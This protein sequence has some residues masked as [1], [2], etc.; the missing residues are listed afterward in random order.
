MPEEDA[1][2]EQ[3][4]RERTPPPLLL[5]SYDRQRV[6]RT[7]IAVTVLLHVLLVLLAL[8]QQKDKPK[9]EPPPD[10][11]AITY[12]MPRKAA[13]KP[14]P[15]PVPVP[16]PTPSKVKPR[17]APPRPERVEME[18]L[19]D[20]ITVPEEKVVEAK[21]APPAAPAPPPPPAKAEPVMDMQEMIAARRQARQRESGVEEVETA[22]QRGDRIARQNIASANRAGRGDDKN[23]TG[24]LFSWKVHSPF[25]AQLKFNGFNKNFNRVWLQDLEIELGNEP[26]IETAIIKKM[27]MLIRKEKKGDFIFRSERQQRDLT[28]SA[29]VEDN[30]ELEN[31]LFKEAFPEH[32][33]SRGKP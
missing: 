24:G 8:W 32:R 15:V 33:R 1:A 26:D 29:R 21:P 30:E 10:L 12:V 6:S 23:G 3:V 11:D 17:P 19:P 13:P 27:V 2:P 5:T 20:T 16:T 25:S 7:G 9:R 28:L 4:A 31:F 22:A 14:S 18:R